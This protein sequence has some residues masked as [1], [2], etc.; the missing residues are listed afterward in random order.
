MLAVAMGAYL[1]SDGKSYAN[2][3]SLP[4]LTVELLATS[5]YPPIIRASE[6][7]IHSVYQR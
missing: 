7:L 5:I 4:A 1:K 6:V 3:F 2:V